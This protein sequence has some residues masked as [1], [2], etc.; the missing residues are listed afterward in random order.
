[1]PVGAIIETTVDALAAQY[2]YDGSWPP[3]DW[4]RLRTL[5][6]SPHF[7]PASLALLCAVWHSL[8]FHR[9]LLSMQDGSQ[10]GWP[11][12]AV[13][14]AKHPPYAAAFSALRLAEQQPRVAFSGTVV[15]LARLAFDLLLYFGI[16]TL[17]LIYY[18][19][20]RP[21]TGKYA[22]LLLSLLRSQRWSVRN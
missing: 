18:L 3:S 21:I 14:V 2:S 10:Y 7:H 19:C 16:P 15:Y 12:A 20:T 8:G 22:A 5:A 9:P 4:P 6:T 1:M 13:I 17:P 11:V